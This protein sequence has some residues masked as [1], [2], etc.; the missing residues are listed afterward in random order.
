MNGLQT[1][2]HQ[3]YTCHKALPTGRGKV[4][5]VRYATEALL[6][7]FSDVFDFVYINPFDIG[8]SVPS[9][10]VPG[11]GGVPLTAAGK[12]KN[13][14]Y[15]PF[16]DAVSVPALHEAGHHWLVHGMYSMIQNKH[17][18]VGE[19]SGHWQMAG[20]DRRGQLGGFDD[21]AIKCKDPAGL[22]PRAPGACKDDKL[23]DIGWYAHKW[24]QKD[25]FLA[26]LAVLQ[27]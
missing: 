18:A 14:I 4:A 10:F 2:S 25:I 26:S 27:K 15:M 5:A 9:S 6:A 16:R 11:G 7:Q 3:E 22:T 13:T 17:G 23:Q 19:I 12:L 21:A 20:L 8:A 24:A 1:G